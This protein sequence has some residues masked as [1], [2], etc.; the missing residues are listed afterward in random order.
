MRRDRGSDANAM[1]V[2]APTKELPMV[3]P[4]YAAIRGQSGFAIIGPTV[5]PITGC[6]D[7][8]CK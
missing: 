1:S 6:E 8:L 2:G 7:A 5:Y 3:A 4:L